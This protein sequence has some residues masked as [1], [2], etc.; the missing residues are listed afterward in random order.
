MKALR[1]CMLLLLI[2]VAAPLFICGSSL[3]ESRPSRLALLPFKMNTPPSLA[4]LQEG[5]DDMLRT[6]L[7]WPGKV[8]LIDR[9]TTFASLKAGGA[10]ESAE[11]IKKW[12]GKLGADHVLFG[13]ITSLGESL[14]L[15]ATLLSVDEASS[16]LHIPIQIEKLDML[17]PAVNQL[18]ETVNDRVYG[19][20]TATLA[21]SQ[22]SLSAPADANRNPEF[23]L[24]QT[25]LRGQ[26][27]SYLNPNF[28]EV[29]PEGSMRQAGIWRSQTLKEALLAI[30]T[31]D[32]DG[33]GRDELVAV[34]SDRLAVFRRVAQG[35]QL[36][37]EHKAENLEHFKWV[38]LAD[39]DGDDRLEIL[40]MCLRQKNKTQAAGSESSQSV[41]ERLEPASKVIELNGNKLVVLAERIPLY[42]NAVHF[43]GRG[44]LA[45]AQQPGRFGELFE[46]DIYE[47]R[48]RD[49]KAVT[50]SPVSLPASCNIFNF[51]TG[52]FNNDGAAEYAVITEDN[53]LVLLDA[54][55]NRI[56]RSRKRFGA[57]TNALIGK[58]EDVRF[59][60][61]E[62]YYIPSPILV[63]D[64]NGDGILELVLN[65]T[66]D[67]SSF[68]PQGYK[69]YE[70][71]EIVSMSWD[72]L[73]LVENWKTREV[74]GM[75]S[76]IRTGD[77]NGD[78]TPELIASLVLGKDLL[79]LWEARSTVFSYDLNVG[80]KA[81]AETARKP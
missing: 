12:A 67:Y 60:R 56:W 33:D 74:S 46:P 9:Q 51:S 35:L 77:L 23:L 30:D 43:P 70:A 42:L 29:T 78:G 22:P 26:S 48:L 28:I 63:M 64:L 55:G 57:T 68:L 52:D 6:R 61:V 45:L 20:E 53:R 66:P 2:L 80:K 31:G 59:N 10:P 1:S 65:R 4:Y 14:S 75:V 40:L 47:F 50:A 38:S 25:L 21:A 54:S 39:V 24:P 72:Q 18:A 44:R 11:E 27:I 19:R 36:L 32:V 62:Y 37:A 58:I 79:K 16:P 71:S 7:A 5:I 8:E 17:I 81:Q 73:G 69:Y 49:G 3:A 13:S 15:D 34:S 76:C 41:D